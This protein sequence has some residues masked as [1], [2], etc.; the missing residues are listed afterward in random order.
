MVGGGG[1]VWCCSL[2]RVLQAWVQA[3][4]YPNGWFWG[5]TGGLS[6]AL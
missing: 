1:C 6:T 3:V 4:L 2:W 5:L